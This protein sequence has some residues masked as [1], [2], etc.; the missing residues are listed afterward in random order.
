MKEQLLEIIKAV[1]DEFGYQY[2]PDARVALEQVE[3]KLLDLSPW[4]SVEDNPS[5]TLPPPL[6]FSSTPR[7]RFSPLQ[8]ACNY[9]KCNGISQFPCKYIKYSCNKKFVEKKKEK[10]W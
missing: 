7:L 6:H 4:V 9:I 10:V 1:R 5:A 3:Q 2:I 8:I